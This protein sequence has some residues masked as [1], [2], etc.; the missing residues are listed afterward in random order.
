MPRQVELLGGLAQP[1][2]HQAV[3][4]RDRL[5]AVGGPQDHVLRH[6][7]Q[8]ARVAENGHLDGQLGH[9]QDPEAVKVHH[10]LEREGHIGEVA[11]EVLERG[12]QV[13][14]GGLGGEL[15]RAVENA[16]V[17]SP[18]LEADV[19]SLVLVPHAAVYAAT[20][21]AAAPIQEPLRNGLAE[22][23]DN[24]GKLW[25]ELLLLLFFHWTLAPLNFE[26]TPPYALA[27]THT[28]SHL[29]SFSL[30]G[31]EKLVND[32]AGAPR[33]ALEELVSDG[34]QFGVLD[35]RLG[36]AALGGPHRH[37]VPPHP[38]LPL[39]GRRYNFGVLALGWERE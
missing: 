1:C 9:A 24:A 25:H 14:P 37:R 20:R 7:A 31:Q 22:A 2:L 15:V 38:V 16:V 32:G 10:A 30:L 6:L 4:R 5:P 36:R 8:V 12:P 28:H 35:P 13:V 23:N 39:L 29:D 18:D 19:P 27:H 26:S 21:L 3:P 33:G 11:L 34:G 17:V